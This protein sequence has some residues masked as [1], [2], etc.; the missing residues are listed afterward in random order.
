M[1]CKFSSNLKNNI[2]S[3]GFLNSDTSGQKKIYC[4]NNSKGKL[5][6]FFN[7]IAI[8]CEN[9]LKILCDIQGFKLPTL[10]SQEA[11]ESCTRHKE[12][13][14]QKGI[15]GSRARA[16]NSGEMESLL[17]KRN[18]R[19]ILA[20]NPREQPFQMKQM[21]ETWRDLSTKIK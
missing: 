15:L 3:L 4:I 11:T 14:N 8:Y 18:P 16:A 5:Q 13:E 12:E 19:G 2:K 10:L 9:R 6:I 7:Q 17:L 21:G 20:R 1:V